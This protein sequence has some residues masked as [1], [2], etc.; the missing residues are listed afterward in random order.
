MMKMKRPQSFRALESR[1]E[2][3]FT[4]CVSGSSGWSSSFVAVVVVLGS[5]LFVVLVRSGYVSLKSKTDSSGTKAEPPEPE[6]GPPK[7]TGPALV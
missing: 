3:C 5:V 4:L 6:T 1:P 7:E 2:S